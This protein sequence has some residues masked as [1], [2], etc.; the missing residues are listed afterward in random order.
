[1][2]FG[3]EMN[4]ILKFLFTRLTSLIL[5]CLVFRGLY[6]L[7]G[8]PVNAVKSLLLGQ[9]KPAKKAGFFVLGNSHSL[10]EFPVWQC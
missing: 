5:K 9:K 7:C 8:K 6:R 2:A 4:V 1:M 10:K 3:I